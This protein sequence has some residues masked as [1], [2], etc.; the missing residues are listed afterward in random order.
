MLNE[1][2]A[3]LEGPTARVLVLG[4]MPSVRSLEEHQY[5]AHPRNA[6]WPIAIAVSTRG[7]P[8]REETFA[9]P[10][11]QRVASITQAGIAVWDVLARCERRGSLDSSIVRDSEEPNDISAFV[12][13]HPE[14]DRIVFN[15]KM[16]EQLFRRYLSGNHDTD[17]C[18]R[19]ERIT[20]PSTSPA[21]ASMTLDDKFA[22]WAKAL[23]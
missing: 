9:L 22:V 12:R 23:G 16:A 7:T 8:T 15:G 13:R 14:L 5:Y 17:I 6:F 10:Y 18:D 2:F 19:I 3:P 11:Q 4:T 21:M 20:A 1:S